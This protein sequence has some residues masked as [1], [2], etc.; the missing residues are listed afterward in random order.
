MPPPTRTADGGPY[1]YHAYD[2]DDAVAFTP[3]PEQPKRDKMQFYSMAKDLEGLY[4]TGLKSEVP[5]IKLEAAG[6][7]HLQ[8]QIL[9]L[10]FGANDSKAPTVIFT[11][12]LHA[13]EWVGAEMAYLLAE[14]LIIHYSKAPANKYAGKIK[15]LIETRNIHILPM[16]NPDGNFYTIFGTEKKDGRDPQNWRKNLRPLPVNP[17]E[18]EK[19]LKANG[20]LNLPFENLQVSSSTVSYLVP[21]YVLPLTN[22]RK[23]ERTLEM[24]KTGVDLNRNYP[25]PAWG[26]DTKFSS[27]TSDASSRSETYFGPEGGSEPETKTVQDFLKNHVP[28]ILIDYHSSGQLILYGAETADKDLHKDPEYASVGATLEALIRASG[29]NDPYT[30]GAPRDFGY[31]G[32]G[33]L[34]DYAALIHQARAFVI[35]LDPKETGGKNPPPEGICAVFEKNIRGALAALAVPSTTTRDALIKEFRDWDVFKRGNQLPLVK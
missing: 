27:D 9:V 10:S 6:Q 31:D 1:H 16:L 5:N 35:E 24:K 2:F 19:A 17:T 23:K 29:E 13:R 20:N 26:Y 33:A 21:E 3:G 18:W 32:T 22:A 12:G 7:S 14:Y 28:A 8:K 34:C 11:G 15:E 4:Q 30:L 25:T